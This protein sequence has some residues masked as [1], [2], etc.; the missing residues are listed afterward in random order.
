M[1]APFWTGGSW[2]AAPNMSGEY[3]TNQLTY[4]GR[5]TN[6]SLPNCTCLSEDCCFEDGQPTGFCGRKHL[7][8]SEEALVTCVSNY[9]NQR[10][11]ANSHDAQLEKLST[12]FHAVR[13]PSISVLDY[14]LRIFKYAFCSRSCFVTAI[15]YLE[16]VAARERS[17]QLTC[18]NVHRLLITSLML[19]AKYLDDIYYNNAYYAKVGGVSLGEMNL[20]ELEF[21]EALNFSLAVDKKEYFLVENMLISEAW[22]CNSASHVL[23]VN[24]FVPCSPSS[25]FSNSG[26]SRCGSTNN[27]KHGSTQLKGTLKY[28]FELIW[29]PISNPVEYNL[30]Y[31]GRYYISQK[32]PPGFE[33]VY[34][35]MYSG[36]VGYPMLDD[37]S[38]RHELSAAIEW[39]PNGVSPVTPE[40]VQVGPPQMFQ[41]PCAR[42]R[43]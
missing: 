37:R 10:V 43:F 26:G 38:S 27:T 33:R 35:N 15:V 14:L 18:L 3:E 17:Y 12:I 34:P 31:N 41:R 39:Y 32:P 4:D 23:A 25:F 5:M 30:I 40:C 8:Q 6:A 42:R 29:R 13:P 21:L 2:Q 19:A 20:L 16:R 9:I 7:F 1:P 24:N 36:N 22:A 28:P 11:T